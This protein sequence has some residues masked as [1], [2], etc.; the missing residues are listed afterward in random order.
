[1]ESEFSK[2]P[3]LRRIKVV[4]N[5]EEKLGAEVGSVF[6]E[7]RDK[8]SAEIGLKMMKGRIYAGTEIKPC[9][10]DEKLYYNEVIIK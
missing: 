7:F 5:G 2:I 10:I 3:H 8:K 1:M 4:R 9:F 6:V